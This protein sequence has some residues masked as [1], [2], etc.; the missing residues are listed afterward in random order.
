VVCLAVSP[1]V[2]RGFQSDKEHSRY[3]LLVTV[4]SIFG[5]G[6]LGRGDAAMAPTTDLFASNNSCF[7]VFESVA[8][9][10]SGSVAV[11]S[12]VAVVVRRRRSALRG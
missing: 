8:L 5:I 10:L 3:G 4:E 7:P 11:A 1:L 6:N 2:K 12:V 9:V